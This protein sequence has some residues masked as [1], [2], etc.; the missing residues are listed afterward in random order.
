MI[1]ERG[2]GRGGGHGRGS[3]SE[4]SGD[5]QAVSGDLDGN[6]QT[7]SLHRTEL[8]SQEELMG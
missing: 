1:S 3:C 7:P 5:D 4:G 6:S 2:G 8:V